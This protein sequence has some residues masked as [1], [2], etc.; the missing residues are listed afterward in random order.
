MKTLFGHL[1]KIHIIGIGGIGM[2]SIAEFLH[3]LGFKLSGS[4]IAFSPI[5]AHL[6]AMGIRVSIGHAPQNIQDAQLIVYSSA[7]K[8]DNPELLEAIKRKIPVIKRPTM[9]REIVKLKH[10]SVGVAGTHG[11]T[12]TSSMLVSVLTEAHCDPTAIIGGIDKVHHSNSRIGN[13]PWLVLE[14]D[15][16]D[17]TFLYLE[18]AMGIVTSIDSDHLDIY[19][20]INDIKEAF[21]Q[22]CNC[23]PFWGCL[24]VCLDNPHIQKILPDISSTCLTYGFNSEADY[25]ITDY[26]FEHGESRFFLTYH[27]KKSGPFMLTLPGKHFVQN[28]AAVATLGLWAEINVSDIQ[29]GLKAYQGVER[30]FDVKGHVDS[31]TFIDD[32]A[33]HPTEI[34]QTLRATRDQWPDRKVLSIF[35]P[36]LYTRTRDFAQDFAEALSESDEVIVTDIYPAREKPLPGISGRLIA[37]AIQKPVFYLEDIQALE[38]I[39]LPLLQPNMVVLAMGA[40]NLSSYFEKF[41]QKLLRKAHDI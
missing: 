16:Y 15:E 30:R 6:Q 26:T 31:I 9:L 36:H 25:I 22:F 40:G 27:N 12:S 7:V 39:L 29:K 2:S 13:T 8:A 17:R 37:D 34:R 35:Q 38:S 19:K 5:T 32:Y 14:A 3:A 24:V 20:D 21:L 23:I 18:P 1:E 41:V 4:D 28:A 33:H 10:F 11:K